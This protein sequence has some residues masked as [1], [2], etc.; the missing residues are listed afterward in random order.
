MDRNTRKA[1]EGGEVLI[2]KCHHRE[3][4]GYYHLKECKQCVG[5]HLANP[6]IYALSSVKVMLS[7]K[8]PANE[9]KPTVC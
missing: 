2:L 4:F 3:A 1:S 9:Q 8:R 6:L 5:E 7:I